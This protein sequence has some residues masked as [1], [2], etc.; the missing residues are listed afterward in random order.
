[1]NTLPVGTPII[2]VG[3]ENRHSY[4]VGQTYVVSYVD[5]SDR[6]LRA[7]D[8]DGH[9]GNWLRW[10]DVRPAVVSDW[11][12]IAASLPEEL[13]AFLSAFDGIADIRLNEKTVD[14]MLKSLPDLQERIVAAAMSPE[15]KAALTANR[16]VAPTPSKEK[17]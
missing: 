9:E 10:S 1:M 13:V 14:A 4:T 17:R 6:T 15:G 7:K 12:R 11:S 8:K 5:P 16:P 2:V 3:N